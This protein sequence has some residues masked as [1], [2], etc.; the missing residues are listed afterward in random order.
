MQHIVLLC[1]FV[2]LS[3]CVFAPELNNPAPHP[4]SAATPVSSENTGRAKS[5]QAV[6]DGLTSLRFGDF[7]RASL[8]FN[9]AVQGDPLQAEAHFLNG[10]AYHLNGIEGDSQMFEYAEVGYKQAIKLDPGHKLAIMQLGRLYIQTHRY[11]DAQDEFSRGLLIDGQNPQFLI[12]LGLS[13]YLAQDLNTAYAAMER[14]E[15]VIP[16]DPQIIQLSALVHAAMGRHCIA[17][18]HFENLKVIKADKKIISN[19]AARLEGW[20]EFYQMNGEHVI[21]DSLEREK[22]KKEELAKRSESADKESGASRRMTFVEATIIRAEATNTAS[23]GDNL[24]K[25]LTLNVSGGNINFNNR[26]RGVGQILQNNVTTS[27]VSYAINVGNSTNN[28]FDVLARPTLLAVDKNTSTFFSGSNLNIAI[29]G[30]DAGGSLEEQEVGIRLEITPKFIDDETV[31]LKI[32]LKSESFQDR[33]TTVQNVSNSQTAYQTSKD[34]VDAN[35]V[36]KLGKTLM[37]SGLNIRTNSYNK[38]GGVPRL[39]DLP[40]VGMMFGERTA[41]FRNQSTIIL[42]TPHPQDMAK[43]DRSGQVRR[44]LYLSEQVDQPKLEELKVRYDTMFALPEG[45]KQQLIDGLSLAQFRREFRPN[46]VLI[47]NRPTSEEVDFV[48]SRLIV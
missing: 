12:G 5:R 41:D 38:N 11:K 21:L 14:A 31:L 20:R 48:T 29:S 28:R 30:N 32:V 43:S 9:K 6:S 3:G 22:K 47:P 2:F 4:A 8:Y 42:I 18:K 7:T 34:Q 39:Q 13:S 1:V 16:S 24:L 36:M 40:I 33:D 44:P 35:V 46:D 25:P 27:Q 37:L 19:I 45:V 23:A 10:F 15:E 26:L 17:E